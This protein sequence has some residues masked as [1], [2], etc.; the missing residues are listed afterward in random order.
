MGIGNAVLFRRRPFSKFSTNGRMGFYPGIWCK[1]GPELAR[2]LGERFGKENVFVRS[3]YH[4]Q[5]AQGAAIHNIWIDGAHVV[6]YRLADQAGGARI[7]SSA[8]ELV[9]VISGHDHDT[10]DLA[11]M[12]KAL[13]LSELIDSAKKS[14]PSSGESRAVFVDAGFTDGRAQFGVVEVAIEADG[15]HVRAESHPCLA[16][17]SDAAEE[18]AIEYAVTWAA[19]DT[20]I[21]SDSK[22]AVERTSKK[23]GERVRWLPRNQNRVADRVA[24]LRGPKKKHRRK[25]KRKSKLE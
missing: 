25:R 7:C 20:V 10:S 8:K 24:N 15:Q 4:L 12:R 13:E 5:V 18:A 22:S 6:K 23:H 14:L 16:D 3:P 17:T 21:F 19:A 1:G 11:N 2:L 9:R